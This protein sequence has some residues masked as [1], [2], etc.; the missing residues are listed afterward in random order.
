MAYR[1]NYA[2]A[3]EG[4]GDASVPVIVTPLECVS[5]KSVCFFP[6]LEYFTVH[7]ISGMKFVKSELSLPL[8]PGRSMFN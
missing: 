4:L 3:G 6:R 5:I 8:L 1:K 7:K 2:F